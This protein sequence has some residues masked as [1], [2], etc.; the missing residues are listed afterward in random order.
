MEDEEQEALALFQGSEFED[1]LKGD[2]NDVGEDDGWRMFNGRT[3]WSTKMRPQSDF[4]DF[5]EIIDSLGDAKRWID[6]DAP[7]APEHVAKLTTWVWP[8]KFWPKR[9]AELFKSRAGNNELVDPSDVAQGGVGDCWLLGSL[10]VVAMYPALF[11]KILGRV[12]H[13]KGVYEIK[14]YDFVDFTP[15]Q[16]CVDMR[17]PS[18]NGHFMGATS[19]TEAELW[20]SLVE[21][22]FAK[23]YGSYQTL[24]HGAPADLA[25]IGLTGYPAK[26]YM[27]YA[28]FNPHFEDPELMWAKLK[29]LCE[30]GHIGCCAF[31][32]GPGLVKNHVYGILGIREIGDYRLIKIRN[33]WGHDGEW[34]GSWGDKSS[35]WTD[36]PDVAT[37]LAYTP[38]NDGMFFMSVEDFAKSCSSMSF[39]RAL[40]TSYAV[41]WNGFEGEYAEEDAVNDEWQ[42]EET[43]QCIDAPDVLQ[44]ELGEKVTWAQSKDYAAQESGRL[45]TLDEARAVL[46]IH[47]ALFQDQDAWESS[48]ATMPTNRALRTLLPSATQIGVILLGGM[49][50][51]GHRA[52]TTRMQRVKRIRV[53]LTP[54]GLCSN[55]PMQMATVP[56]AVLNFHQS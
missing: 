49:L 52:A 9:K 51:F 43:Y 12:D 17:L 8:E 54:S 50:S 23:L 39:I 45:L 46:A 47:G 29:L 10:S 4:R 6:E 40:E 1:T 38:G 13:Q 37:E 3:C 34:Q 18:L 28:S 15:R 26:Q 56:S 35:L 53:A 19:K 14:L 7:A 21:K 11:M 16:V 25:L 32:S 33:P 31:S 27:N 20:P 36:C 2:W 24:H 41:E 30:S 42:D 5:Q 44:H 22:A 55:R 48:L